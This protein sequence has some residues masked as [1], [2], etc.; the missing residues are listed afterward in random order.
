MLITKFEYFKYFF[1]IGVFWPIT[2]FSLNNNYPTMKKIDESVAGCW[3][4]GC[5]FRISSLKSPI[6]GLAIENLKFQITLPP[7]RFRVQRFMVKGKK[8]ACS[9]NF[10]P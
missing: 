10:K 4:Y 2:R 6:Y 3:I 9:A 7:P 5:Q 1:R 8:Q